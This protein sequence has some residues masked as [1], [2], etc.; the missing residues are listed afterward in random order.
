MPLLTHVLQ[1]PAYGYEA[2]RKLIIPTYRQLFREFFVRQNILKTR[3][4][5]LA[6]FGWTSSC[7][8][9]IPL[10]IF[11][12]NYFS[13]TLFFYGFIYSMVILGTHGTVWYHRYSTHRAYTFSHPFWRFLVKNLVIKISDGRSTT[14]NTTS[15]THG[16]FDNDEA[17]MNS[18][19]RAVLGLDENPERHFSKEELEY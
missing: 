5:W 15:K 11:A 18:V 17:T 2:N 3:K 13:W 4:N 10:I 1:P 19:L 16:G 6:L 8:F 9:V 7:L 12:T 14:R